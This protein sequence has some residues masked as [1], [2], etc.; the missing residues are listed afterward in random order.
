MKKSLLFVF[1]AGLLLLCAIAFAANNG[2][3]EVPFV[4]IVSNP[5][6]GE[7]VNLTGTLHLDST[8]TVNA[9]NFHMTSHANPQGITGIGQTSGA[10]YHA[11]GVTRSDSGGS[12]VDGAA[13]QT[14]INRFHIVGDGRTPNF[15]AFNTVHVTLNADGTM[16][17]NVSNIST[18]CH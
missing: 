9:N 2:Q 3:A 15:E 12:L 11:T 13:E 7:M 1:G 6:L 5:C 16:T 8:V 14:F 4:A 10:I 17:A 18:T